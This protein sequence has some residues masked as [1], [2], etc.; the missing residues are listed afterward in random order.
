MSE[1]GSFWS[2]VPGVVTGAAGVLTALVGLLTVALQLGWIGG[3]SSGGGTAPSTTG[4][5][6][7]SAGSS[8]QS[9]STVPGSSSGTGGT[10]GT[11]QTGSPSGAG[12]FTVEPTSVDFAVVGARQATVVV[13]NTGDVP[14]TIK[15]PRVSGSGAEHFVAGDVSCTKEPLRPGR[16][17]EVQVVFT[18]KSPGAVS[19]VAV[20]AA[21]EAS[22]ETEIQL[23]GSTLLG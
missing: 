1:R 23:K 16:T 14:L 15:T 19:A 12:Q 11:G 2:T 17:C 7:A 4:V 18:P 8:I 13:R 3:G 10:A 5:P 22:R 6:G 21:T 20:I 9:G